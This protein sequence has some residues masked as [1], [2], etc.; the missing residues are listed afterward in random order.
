[1]HYVLY[2]SITQYF[3]E[4]LKRNMIGTIHYTYI[5]DILTYK[6]KKNR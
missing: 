5:D 4:I 2:Y 6:Y 3:K 1:M